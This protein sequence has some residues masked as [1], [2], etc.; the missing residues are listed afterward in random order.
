MYRYMLR[1]TGSTPRTGTIHLN[2]RG[3][4]YGGAVKVAGV[5]NGVPVLQPHIEGVQ[6][7]SR[8]VPANSTVSVALEIVHAGA[9]NLPMAI[10]C[11]TV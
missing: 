9:T 2:G 10:L 1:N 4:I 8:T 7:A 5:T 11:R 3:G 6:V